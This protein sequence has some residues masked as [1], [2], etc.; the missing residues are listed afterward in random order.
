MPSA[1]AA[2]RPH[3]S[4]QWSA[5]SNCFVSSDCMV[6]NVLCRPLLGQRFQPLLRIQGLLQHALA[7]PVV[8]AVGAPALSSTAA[9]AAPQVP[10]FHQLDQKYI[11]NLLERC[12]EQVS[13]SSNRAGAGA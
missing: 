7:L 10:A 2:D 5:P 1:A 4:W 11:K 8:P 13:A 6:S 3:R 12:R 9:A